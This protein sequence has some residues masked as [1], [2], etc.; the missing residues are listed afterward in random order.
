MKSC[1]SIAFVVPWFGEKI[2]GG[3]EA[4]TRGI[5]SHLRN[6]GVRVTVLT[7]CIEKFASDWS[8]NAFTPG[9]Y[10]A[11]G[12]KV[13][14]FSVERRDKFLFDGLNRK[15]LEG[16]HISETEEKL[17]IREMIRCPE[18]KKYIQQHSGEY[19][20]LFAMPYMFT[21]V[22]DCATV[23]PEKTIL[24]P[25]FHDESYAWLKVY[26]DVFSK[27]R[28]MAFLS[29]PEK[30]LAAKIF[31]VKGKRFQVIGLGVDTD[32]TY[33]AERFRGKYQIYEP[34][35]L[36]AGRKE[37][38]KKVDELIRNFIYY[39]WRN[40]SDLKLVLLG[41]GEIDTF[42]HPDILDIGFVS[43][44]DKYDAYAAADL[45]VNPSEAESFSIVIMESWLANTPVMVNEACQ[46]TTNF[47]Q[48][49]H[50]GLY[51]SGYLDFEGAL[52]Y[53][54]AHDDVSMKMSRNG[55]E[56]VLCNYS[57]EAVTQRYLNF[58][59]NCIS[60]EDRE[61]ESEVGN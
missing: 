12:V 35:L 3:A 15:L 14:R 53:F 42:D 38:G 61:P 50:A 49:S 36:Y 58:I 10:E 52:N 56:F 47:V 43:A 37:T 23:C 32:S 33:D 26:K 45:F 8:E 48:Q 2:P 34:F 19:D 1:P 4:A 41:G 13:I 7:T 28:G 51:Y 5:V 22:Y 17:F 18:L 29:E 60:G 40:P 6:S 39:K 16:K 11:C 55:R 20:L 30:A 9:E 57:W 54:Q 59:R 25:C 44:Q 21:P 27:V 31:G 46:V 24:I